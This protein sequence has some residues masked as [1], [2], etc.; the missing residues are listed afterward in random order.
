[1]TYDITIYTSQDLSSHC[2]Y[3]Y[4]DEQKAAKVVRAHLD[5]S[6]S[7]QN[8]DHNI[9]LSDDYSFDVNDS[10]SGSEFLD[11]FD[12]WKEG[13]T[14]ESTDANLILSKDKPSGAYSG[15]GEVETS[16][17]DGA[18]DACY[19][20]QGDEIA[21]HSLGVDRYG[22]RGD[23]TEGAIRGAIHEVGH[24]IGINHDDGLRYDESGTTYATPMGCDAGSS[25]ACSVTCSSNST[26][27]WDHYWGECEAGSTIDEPD[28]LK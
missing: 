6:L 13:H 10:W 24:N 5:N 4:D 19:K 2:W 22:D 16:S 7:H 15:L 23:P 27:K 14:D 25:N 17:T 26:D 3:Y 12:T 28:S 1:M 21:E 18:A 20:K 9:T 8:L 11:E